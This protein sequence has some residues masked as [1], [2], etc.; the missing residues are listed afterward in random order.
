MFDFI[1]EYFSYDNAPS[2]LALWSIGRCTA[3]FAFKPVSISFLT[4]RYPT[5]SSVDVY[6]YNFPDDKRQLKLLGIYSSAVRCYV[7]L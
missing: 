2:S 7:Y 1:Y 3:F 6:S 5:N 4:F